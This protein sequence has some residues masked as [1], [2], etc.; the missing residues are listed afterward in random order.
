MFTFLNRYYNQDLILKQR[1]NEGSFNVDG[2]G[3]GTPAYEHPKGIPSQNI[4]QAP[5]ITKKKKQTVYDAVN[6]IKN[7]GMKGL[8]DHKPTSMGQFQDISSILLTPVAI[9]NQ[10]NL[11]SDEDIHADENILDEVINEDED[12]SSKKDL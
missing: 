8:G 10:Q 11:S 2:G 3:T 6:S 9:D 1:D 4:M 12:E 7:M 5:V